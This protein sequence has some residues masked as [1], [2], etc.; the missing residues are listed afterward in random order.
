MLDVDANNQTLDSIHY[1]YDLTGANTTITNSGGTVSKEYDEETG[2]L[3]KI[4]YPDERSLQYEYYWKENKRKITNPFGQV[5]WIEYD[6]MNRIQNVKL[7]SE[8]NLP[9]A[10][11][12]Y[13]PNSKIKSKTY[14]N[15]L[16]TNY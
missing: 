6:Q 13:T 11:Y 7:D 14:Q 2:E 15:G 8:T 5:T 3:L 1:Q 16:V 4:T 12:D 10:K 9:I